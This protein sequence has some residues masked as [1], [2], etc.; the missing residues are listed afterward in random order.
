ME[1]IRARMSE[2]EYKRHPRDVKYP[3][4]VHKNFLASHHK[5]VSIKAHMF[6]ALL[7]PVLFLSILRF[8]C[9]G[10]ENE[11]QTIDTGAGCGYN[12][13]EIQKKRR[14]DAFC[15]IAERR[16]VGEKPREGK[17]R[18]PFLC[19]RHRRTGAGSTG[20]SRR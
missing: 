17:G 15:P 11:C 4:A 13:K 5:K 16:L 18:P 8:L 10:R 2:I 6:S 1:E 7:H 20:V 3:L 19:Q 12:R 9:D 14:E